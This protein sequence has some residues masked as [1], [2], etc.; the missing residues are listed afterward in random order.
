MGRVFTLA[1]ASK[2][3]AIGATQAKEAALR[4]LVS[5]A[6][7]TVQHIQTEIIPA[8]VPTPVNRGGYNAAWRVEMLDDGAS[9]VNTMPYA[10]MIERGVRAENVKIGRKM[11][12]A[13][14]EWIKMKGI[15]NSTR[16]VKSGKNKGN[17][18]IVKATQAEIQSI[19]WAMAKS[20]QKYGIFNRGKGLRVLERAT[21]SI[22]RFIRLE[23]SRELRKEFY[24]R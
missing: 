13:L 20:F 6:Y 9:V 7:R 4:G 17:T 23:V 11:I 10:P 2:W 22:P 24:G 18:K 15:G 5:A 14:A 8:T 3:L 19:A 16:V 12:D 21:K 1:S